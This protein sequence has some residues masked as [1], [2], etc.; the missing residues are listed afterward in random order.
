MKV[1]ASARLLFAIPLGLVR[2]LCGCND[3]KPVPPAPPVSTLEGGAD[4]QTGVIRYLAMGDSIS[5]GKGDGKE[6]DFEAAAFPTKLATRWRAQ[7]RKVELKILGVAHAT[8]QEVVTKQLPEIA[9]FK[10]TFITFQS[11]SNDIATKVSAEAYRTNVR[12]ILEGATKSGARVVVIGQ[13]EWWRSPHGKGYGGTQEKRDA[14]DAILFEETRSRRGAELVDLRHLYR[15]QADKKAW[16]E[17]GIHPTT[18]AYDEM[19]AELARV[20]PAPK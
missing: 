8:T 6:S 17:D 1:R 3:L 20:V 2:A 11:G 7:G 5:Q 14:F 18:A 10:P 12:A 15:Q 19:A 4:P 9:A 13:N 16:A